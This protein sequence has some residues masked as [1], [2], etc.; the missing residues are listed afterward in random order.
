MKMQ[1]GNEEIYLYDSRE[2]AARSLGN[3]FK[4]VRGTPPFHNLEDVQITS[5]RM[6]DWGW[7]LGAERPSSKFAI[8]TW[9]GKC[10]DDLSSPLAQALLYTKLRPQIFFNMKGEAD[11]SIFSNFYKLPVTFYLSENKFEGVDFLEKKYIFP[12]SE[13]LYQSFK[14]TNVK[15][16]EAVLQCKT[17]GDAKKLVRSFPKRDDWEDVKFPLMVIVEY[18]KFS[19]DTLLKQDLL[20]TGEAEIIEVADQWDDCTWGIGKEGKG[21][22]WLGLAIM[23]AREHLKNGTMPD[24]SF[25]DFT[26]NI[27]EKGE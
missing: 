15:Q 27:L 7:V 2:E 18:L 14:A 10:L 23:V 1:I 8:V 9:H 13:H 19:Q 20:S 22:N 25:L 16:F 26:K 11:K 17:P 24:M 4:T 12:T 5:V 3:E 21:K 6:I